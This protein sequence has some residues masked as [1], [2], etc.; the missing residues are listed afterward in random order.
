MTTVFSSATWSPDELSVIGQLRVYP[1]VADDGNP[2]TRLV[3]GVVEGDARAARAI[4]R[5]EVRDL[6]A[7]LD[8]FL[9]EG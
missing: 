7:A 6:R 2:T 1:E 9:G 4:D 3:F 5:Q 8:R